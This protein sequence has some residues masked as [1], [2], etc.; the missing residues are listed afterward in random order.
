LLLVFDNNDQQLCNY[1]DL[2]VSKNMKTNPKLQRN[3]QKSHPLFMITLILIIAGCLSLLFTSALK[4]SKVSSTT[5]AGRSALQSGT[6]PNSGMTISGLSEVE[7]ASAPEPTNGLIALTLAPASISDQLPDPDEQ[8]LMM[9]N[10]AQFIKSMQA[11]Q[12]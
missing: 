5:I 12:R 4:P 11:N 3:G 8:K 9:E 7:I 2:A 1:A 6:S 10:N